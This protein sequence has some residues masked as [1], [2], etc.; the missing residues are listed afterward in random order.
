MISM[1]I[2]KKDTVYRAIDTI[3]Y[4]P[5]LSGLVVNIRIFLINIR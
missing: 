3:N 4:V 1:K 2:L 5:T